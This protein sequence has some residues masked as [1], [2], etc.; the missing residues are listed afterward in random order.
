M[1][2]KIFKNG[3]EIGTYDEETGELTSSNELL[4][5][6]A[7]TG[8]DTRGGGATGEGDEE[9]YFESI[10]RRRPGDKGFSFALVDAGMEAG[11]TFSDATIEELLQR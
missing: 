1:R 2:F 10:G 6:W 3:D 7:E 5:R 9:V 11:F 4:A 8:I